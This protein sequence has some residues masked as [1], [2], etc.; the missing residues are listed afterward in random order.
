MLKCK[1]GS[2]AVVLAR[3]LREF[4]SEIYNGPNFEKEKIAITLEF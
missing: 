4:E 2:T 3:K 1:V